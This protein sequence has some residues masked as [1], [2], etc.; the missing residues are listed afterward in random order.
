MGG[1]PAG[2]GLATR[3]LAQ[4]GGNPPAQQRHEGHEGTTATIR[5]AA[6]RHRMKPRRI[7]ALQVGEAIFHQSLQFQPITFGKPHG[8]ARRALRHFR[9]L[10][11][12]S[13]RR[14]GASLHRRGLAPCIAR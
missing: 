2:R 9:E 13:R 12:I 6:F 10:G 14:I 3:G 8:A 4:P 11:A 7:G 5:K 1:D